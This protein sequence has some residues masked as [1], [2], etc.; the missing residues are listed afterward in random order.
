MRVEDP[1]GEVYYGRRGYPGVLFK[2]Q[3][4]VCR[5]RSKGTWL[6][7]PRVSILGSRYVD[8]KIELESCE[9]VGRAKV[10]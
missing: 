5:R 4:T 1:L 10:T 6:V 7:E 3:R 9:I 8:M 2:L